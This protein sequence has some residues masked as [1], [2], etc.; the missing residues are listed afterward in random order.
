MASPQA[1]KHHHQKTTHDIELAKFTG[2]STQM[3]GRVGEA[4]EMRCG[5]EERWRR[6][7]EDL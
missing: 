5:G 1:D 4:E 6:A 2:T 3:A 7:E